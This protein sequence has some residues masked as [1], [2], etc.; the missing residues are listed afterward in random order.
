MKRDLE[1]FSNEDMLKPS[2]DSWYVVGPKL[3]E[4]LLWSVD[5]PTITMI[6]GQGSHTEFGL[7]CDLTIAVEGRASSNRISSW[8]CAWRCAVSCVSEVAWSEAREPYDVLARNQYRR[9]VGPGVGHG[10]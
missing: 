2:Y 3:I 7:L 4:N 9:R 1:S 8:R 10:W 5:I 6:N